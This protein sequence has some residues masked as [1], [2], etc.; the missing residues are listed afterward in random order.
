MTSEKVALSRPSARL[1]ASTEI[2]KK[3]RH[4]APCYG[5]FH[6]VPEFFWNDKNDP[7]NGFEPDGL[8]FFKLVHTG[9]NELGLRLGAPEARPGFHK[10]EAT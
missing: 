6:A 7:K 9:V 8:F 3:N 4:P 10:G 1:G 2:T 5:K